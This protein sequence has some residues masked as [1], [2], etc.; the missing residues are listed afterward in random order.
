M[1]IQV[2]GH[3]SNGLTGLATPSLRGLEAFDAKLK[4]APVFTDKPVNTGVGFEI[5]EE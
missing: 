4:I 3:Q 2:T 1:R 5:E